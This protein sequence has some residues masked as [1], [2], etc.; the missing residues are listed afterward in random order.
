MKGLPRLLPLA[1]IA[2][3]GVLGVKLASSVSEMPQLV[4][5]AQAKTDEASHPAK[6][7]A[8]G[9]KDGTTSG[10]EPVT[11]EDSKPTSATTALPTDASAAK[12]VPVCVASASDFAKEAGMSPAEL[13]IL[14][15]L[16]KRRGQLDQRESEI[17]AQ[18][19][20]LTAA[21]A[22][23]DA[24][25]KALDGVKG[26]IKSLMGQ[27]DAQQQAETS[28]M[29]IVFSGM[30]PKDAAAR[31][32]LL[33]DAVRLPIAAKMKERTLAAVLS[34]MAPADAKALTEKLAQRFVDASAKA[35][36]ALNGPP[37]APPPA[38][39]PSPQKGRPRA[40]PPKKG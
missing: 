13:Q 34:Q 36:S 10:S 11:S 32:T 8:G 24:K 35:Q 7:K 28:R 16:G 19:Q 33:S 26:E 4:A 23:V 30:K 17:D 15:T 29:V 14:Q 5:G 38:P 39:E 20:L 40:A 9:S 21:E 1:G 22:K 37:P 27:M 12:A 3:I 18:M 6:S 2:V 25:L 31:M